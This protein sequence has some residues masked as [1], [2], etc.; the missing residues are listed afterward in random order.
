[1]LLSGIALQFPWLTSCSA[2]NDHTIASYPLSSIQY[3]IIREVQEILF[4]N[5]GNGPSASQI[6]ADKY[7]LWVLKDPLLDPEETNFILNGI[8]TFN[9]A[10]LTNHKANFYTLF[11]QD[12]IE[13]VHDMTQEPWAERWISR[14]LTL[15]FEAL[16]LDPQYGVNPNGTGWQWLNHDP[17]QPRPH[18]KILYPTILKKHEI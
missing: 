5:D 16:L 7:L 9:N 13:F 11:E 8:D 6:H 3:K 12:K 4:P 17:G 18:S 14:L 1:M 15:I 10:C 2:D